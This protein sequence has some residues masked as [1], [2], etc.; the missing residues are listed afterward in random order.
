MKNVKLLSYTYPGEIKLLIKD[1]IAYT[2]VSNEYFCRRLMLEFQYGA[3]FN[4]L[5]RFKKVSRVIR[6]EVI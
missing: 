2:Y 4:A 6:K 5:N 1:S 3:G